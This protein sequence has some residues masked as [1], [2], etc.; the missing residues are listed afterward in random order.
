MSQSAKKNTKYM[1]PNELRLG[2]LF[3]PINRS[4]HVHIPI[5]IPFKILS[6]GNQV[7]A[8]KFDQIPAQLEQIPKFSLRD[9]SEIDITGEWLVR[10]GFED[11][12][13]NYGYPV[14]KLPSFDG[15]RQF[16]Y[17]ESSIWIVT[18]GSG[19]GWELTNI[20]YIHQLQNLFFAIT[21]KELEMS[22]A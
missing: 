21:G 10:F 11:L 14:F 8:V 9:L 5:E 15:Q 13:K 16:R 3:Y 2:N 1:K 22:P 6:I 19:W 4:G 18:V 17:S 7:E 12:T 20:K